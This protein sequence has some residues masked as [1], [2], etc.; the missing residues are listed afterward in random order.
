[1]VANEQG[2]EEVPGKFSLAQ[3]YPNPFN[4]TTQIQFHL[5]KATNVKLTVYS[6]NGQRVGELVNGF[7][8][9]GTHRVQFDA[10]NLASGVYIYQLVADGYSEVKRMLLIK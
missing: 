4:P 1:M 10:S 7:Q 2:F 6:I 3:N 9:A 5:P 8:S